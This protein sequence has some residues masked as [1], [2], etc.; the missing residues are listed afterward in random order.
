MAGSQERRMGWDVVGPQPG[1]RTSQVITGHIKSSVDS[2]DF[3]HSGSC[4]L[5]LSLE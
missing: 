2:L 5:A 1:C 4:H 3:A